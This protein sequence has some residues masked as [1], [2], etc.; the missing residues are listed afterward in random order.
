MGT[1]RPTTPMP[2]LSALR[3]SDQKRGGR[4]VAKWIGIIAIA[5]LIIAAGVWGASLLRNRAPEVEVA[6][7]AA[8]N[9]SPVGALLNASGYVTPRRRASVAAKITGKILDVYVDEGVHVT[10]GQVLA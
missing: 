8:P 3:I 5:I 7:A 2:D 10:Q 6:A 9:S 4:P 1:S